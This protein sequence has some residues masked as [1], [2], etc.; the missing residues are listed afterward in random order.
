MSKL[1]EYIGKEQALSYPFANGKY[2]KENANPDFIKG[3]ESYKEWLES[4][5][6]HEVK[7]LEDGFYAIRNGV[8]YKLNLPIADPFKNAKKVKVPVIQVQPKAERTCGNCKWSV[9]KDIPE[10]YVVCK[11]KDRYIMPK[12]V[13]MFNKACERWEKE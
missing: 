2:D 7:D 6:A 9:G 11:N 1:E 5:P 3:C 4:Q 12:A 8:V 13:D 10:T